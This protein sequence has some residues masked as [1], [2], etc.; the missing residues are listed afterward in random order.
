[1]Y[2]SNNV[3]KDPCERISS[4]PK[5]FKRKLTSNSST[6][7]IFQNM[8]IPSEISPLVSPHKKLQISNEQCLEA[9]NNILILNDTQ[10]R[11]ESILEKRLSNTEPAQIEKPQTDLIPIQP[12]L[13]TLNNLLKVPSCNDDEKLS[14]INQTQSQKTSQN[15]DINVDKV[16]CKDSYAREKLATINT[17]E[18][19]TNKNDL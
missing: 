8:A 16:I 3:S 17:P 14:N 1:M 10:V 7:E 15:E 19:Q 11:T 18:I 5:K 12:S 6:E 13:E 2:S 9:V 4:L